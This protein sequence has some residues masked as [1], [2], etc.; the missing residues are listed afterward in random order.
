MVSVLDR[1]YPSNLRMIHQ[2]PP[3]LFLRGTADERDA[4][5]VAV[6]GTRKA[7][8]QGLNQAKDLA[9]GLAA[10]GVPVISGLAAGIDAAASRTVIT[11]S[12]CSPLTGASAASAGQQHTLICAFALDPGARRPRHHQR[13]AAGRDVLRLDDP[14]PRRRAERGAPRHGGQDA[15]KRGTPADGLWPTTWL[16]RGRS[17][18]RSP[19]KSPRFSRTGACDDRTGRWRRKPR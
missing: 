10:R 6:V 5:S 1:E 14:R 13:A 9:A 12:P 7:S 8:P 2:R 18:R 4:V 11:S 17:S 16:R 19:R 15:L 3:V